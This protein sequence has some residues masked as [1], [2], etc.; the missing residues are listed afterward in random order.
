MRPAN[1]TEAADALAWA[2]QLADFVIVR[3]VQWEPQAI[4]SALDSRDSAPFDAEW[5][6]TDQAVRQHLGQ[7]DPSKLPWRQMQAT[8]AS[9]S[10]RPC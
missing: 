2:S 7:L 1:Q 3:A 5:V 9:A 8:C 6:N 10:S 4:D